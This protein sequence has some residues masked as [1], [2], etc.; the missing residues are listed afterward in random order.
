[1]AY[2]ELAAHS[3][4]LLQPLGSVRSRR[5]FGGHGLYVDDLFIALIA[6][7]RLFLKV[8]DLTRANFEAA[9]CEPF[10]YDGAGK[11]VTVGY[12]T[13]PAD[14]MESPAL[15]LFWGRLAM[16]A[17]LRARAAK[18]ATKRRPAAARRAGEAAGPAQAVQPAAASAGSR[19]KA[20]SGRR[21]RA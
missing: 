5:M 10:V 14:A 20:G 12:F 8:D 3:V 6:F 18:P 21:G 2:E 7:D 4:E 15:M 17:A 11:Q 19:T 9:G 1:M 13:V 16:E